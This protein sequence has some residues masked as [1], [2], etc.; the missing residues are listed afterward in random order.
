MD[1]VE[2]K[3][4]ATT[5]DHKGMVSVFLDFPVD[6]LAFDFWVMFQLWHHIILAEV[7]SG[8]IVKRVSASFELLALKIFRVL[9]DDLFV[10]S[11]SSDGLVY[12]IRSFSIW[13]YKLVQAVASIKLE[14]DH[15]FLFSSFSSTF[16]LI[17]LKHLI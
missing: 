15:E 13:R 10:K 3:P 14:V 6:L 5:W 8:V 16:T 4:I 11:S 12:D 1:G 7:N 17:T 9:V 2:I